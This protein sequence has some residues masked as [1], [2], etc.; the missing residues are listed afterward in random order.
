MLKKHTDEETHDDE[1]VHDEAVVPGH[2]EE[3]NDFDDDASFEDWKDTW[4]RRSFTRY[5][6]DTPTGRSGLW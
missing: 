3:L 5:R 2:I 1:D 4:Y 6:A